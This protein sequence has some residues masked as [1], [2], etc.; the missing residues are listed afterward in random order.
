MHTTLQRNFISVVLKNIL[1]R[2]SSSIMPTADKLTQNCNASPVLCCK[3]SPEIFSSSFIYAKRPAWVVL[4]SS[5]T[6]HLRCLLIIRPV[7]DFC[8]I[9]FFTYIML[10]RPSHAFLLQGHTPCIYELLNS[11]TLPKR[12]RECK[13]TNLFDRFSYKASRAFSSSGGN[14]VISLSD[15]QCLPSCRSW[16]GEHFLN[17]LDEFIAVDLQT[18][19]LGYLPAHSPLFQKHADESHLRKRNALSTHMKYR[20]AQKLNEFLSSF[21]TVIEKRSGQLF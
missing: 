4:Y 20:D 21:S 3:S 12:L 18:N 13:N 14:R 19:S 15:P 17:V 2:S 8:A 10:S 9:F 1:V 5:S 11:S 16:V 6:K 7:L